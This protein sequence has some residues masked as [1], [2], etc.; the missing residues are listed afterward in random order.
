M[1]NIPTYRL[2][3]ALTALRAALVPYYGAEYH[4]DPIALGLRSVIG[5]IQDELDERNARRAA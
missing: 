3:R 1:K 4:R 5:A 2:H